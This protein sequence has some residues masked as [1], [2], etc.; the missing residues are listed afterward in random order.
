MLV[1]NLDLKTKT[2]QKVKCGIN[3]FPF[4]VQTE[5]VKKAITLKSAKNVYLLFSPYENVHTV[6]LNFWGVRNHVCENI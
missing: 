1:K 2:C 3:Q 4:I 6:I 5:R